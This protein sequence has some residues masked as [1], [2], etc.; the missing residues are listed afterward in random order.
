MSQVKCPSCSRE[1]IRRV[2]RAGLGE[3]LAGWFFIYPFKCQICGL[4]F[5]SLKWGVRY[6]RLRPDHR[7]YDR[8]GM[9]FPVLFRGD[10]FDGAGSVTDISMGG[11]RF[12][13]ASE[14]T[15]RALMRLELKVSE[16]AA[17]VIVDL[18]VL[19]HWHN[20][21]AGVE[22]LRCEPS[23]RERLQLFVQ[24]LLIGRRS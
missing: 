21:V 8:M 19:R 17:P 3:R 10:R 7:E 11:C 13:T 14:L 22:F 4:R 5:R 12:T 9:N 15:K 24:G 1:F 20:Q 6:L 16:E 18:A 23:E 2:V